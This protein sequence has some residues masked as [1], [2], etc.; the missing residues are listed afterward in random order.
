MAIATRKKV[1]PFTYDYIPK[2]DLLIG[3]HKLLH[4]GVLLIEKDNPLIGK[5]FFKDMMIPTTEN[6][7]AI[8]NV[9]FD[10][11]DNTMAVYIKGQFTIIDYEKCKTKEN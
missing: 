8:M 5:Y 10:P 6:R 3:N 11:D 7:L 2:E 4:R 9:L 1:I